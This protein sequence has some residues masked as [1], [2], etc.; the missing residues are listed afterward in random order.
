MKFKKHCQLYGLMGL[1][2]LSIGITNPLIGNMPH[3]SYEKYIIQEKPLVDILK[4]MGERY[5]VFFTYE[6]ELLEGVNV[7][8]EFRANESLE[9]AIQRLLNDT[10]FRH[11]SFG[12]KFLVI[13]QNTR[14]GAKAAK[15]MGRKI[16]QLKKRLYVLC[17]PKSSHFPAIHTP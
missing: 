5:K 1:L 6:V 2:F 13:Y 4:E 14:R 15:K 8:F 11:K 16:Q 12:D 10:G 3:T 7:N 9:T 17:F